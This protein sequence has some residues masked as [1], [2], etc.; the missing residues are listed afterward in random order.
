MEA[1]LGAINKPKAYLFRESDV[2]SKKFVLSYISDN[3]RGLFKHVVVPTQSAKKNY[4]SLLEAYSVME[5]MIL[6]SDHCDNPVPPLSA[7]QKTP[8]L[9][10]LVCFTLVL[11]A[12]LRQI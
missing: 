8:E 10:S 2:K 4:S 1:R 12:K 11:L 9:I 6:C 7:V 3:K 5:R